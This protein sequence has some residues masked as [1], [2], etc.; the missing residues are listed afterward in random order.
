[1]ANDASLG[2][3]AQAPTMTGNAIVIAH[4]PQT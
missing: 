4:L 2:V 1:M 3:A